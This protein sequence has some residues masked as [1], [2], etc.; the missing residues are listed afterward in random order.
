MIGESFKFYF[1]LSALI[2]AVTSSVVGIYIVSVGKTAKQARD[3]FR[4]CIA[5]GL[6][7]YGYFFWQLAD[8]PDSALF[9]S[10]VL[11]A[12]AIL[13]A[14][15]YIHLVI[16]F[17]GLS[18]QSFYKITLRI[19]Y[20]FSFFWL[21]VDMTPYFVAGVEPRLLFDFWPVPGPFYLP[22]LI[23]FGFEFMYATFLLIRGYHHAQGNRRR[24]LMLLAAGGFIGFIGGSTNYLL[25]FNVPVAPWGNGLVVVY[26]MLTVYAILKYKLL[27]VQVITAELFAALFF[28]ILLADTFL[29]S[30]VL[31]LIYRL[32]ALGIMIVFGVM[33]VRSVREEVTRRKEVTKLAKS[34]E[35]ANLR[36][37]ELDRQKT[38]FLSIASHQL[39]TPLSI[40]K[41]YL[42]L[43]G[44]GAYGKVT[45]KM[46]EILGDMD[47]SNERLVKLVDDFL[48][49]TRIEQG[50]TKFSFD[51]YDMN[52]IVTSVVN[53]LH[54]RA[55]DRKLKLLWQSGKEKHMMY[56]DDEKIRHVIFNYVDNA[57]KYTPKGSI[58][59]LLERGDD[60][61][62]VKVSDTGIGFGKE[63][64]ANFFQ[65]FYRGKNVES[66]N[67]NGTGLG[68]YVCKKFIETHGGRVWA[69]SG[70]IGKGSEFGF[71]LPKKVGEKAKVIP[72]SDMAGA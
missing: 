2:N 47:E 59:V 43:I 35:Q 56:M 7:S 22:F 64:E 54:D 8:T 37:Q 46:R 36:L 38:E 65:K 52:D 27:N 53:E 25:W 20:V 69:K 70:G 12:G 39:R 60:G 26:F 67:V 57:I 24:Q 71:W 19:L 31:E 51:M 58:T 44:D 28:I 6:W 9:W 5:I 68:I 41:G 61:L 11:M 42:E 4:F 49:I 62:T 48:D 17:L 50:R 14:L 1:P 32:V 23:G 18:S 30:S 72:Q 34:L 10:R 29:S 13:T 16:N 66:T 40:I 45:K 33:L 3:I 21:L 15:F 55:K 63:D